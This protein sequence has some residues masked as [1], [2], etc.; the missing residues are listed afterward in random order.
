ML[1]RILCIRDIALFQFIF[2]T[3]TNWFIRISLN[4]YIITTCEQNPA[5]LGCG[6]GEG[7]SQFLLCCCRA[8]LFSEY[9]EAEQITANVKNVIKTCTKGAR[10][11]TP[12][13]TPT[14]NPIQYPRGA[15]FTRDGTPSQFS[16]NY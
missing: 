11:A 14:T 3:K 8:C 12:D 5:L 4:I 13:L 7:S 15:K 6:R 2:L 9:L 16:S 1:I 10:A